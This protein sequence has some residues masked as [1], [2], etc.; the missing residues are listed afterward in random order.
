[1]IGG[2]RVLSTSLRRSWEDWPLFVPSRHCPF[3]DVSRADDVVAFLHFLVL[4]AIAQQEPGL[5]APRL[6]LLLTSLTT[7][8]SLHTTSSSIVGAARSIWLHDP[9]AAIDPLAALEV[10]EGAEE[11]GKTSIGGEG[12]VQVGEEGVEMD[13]GLAVPHDD[14]KMEE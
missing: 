3:F 13:G 9:S 7:L 4:D 8:S 11:W 12:D 5:T 10:E 6:S 14:T 1:M 2:G